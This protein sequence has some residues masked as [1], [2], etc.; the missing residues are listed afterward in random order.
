[1]S[2]TTQEDESM[3]ARFNSVAVAGFVAVVLSLGSGGCRA[4]VPARPPDVYTVRGVV[5]KLPQTNGP[6]KAV[7]IHHAPIPGFRNER[8]KVVGMMSMT[9]PFPVAPG[10][11]LAGIAPGDPVKFTFTVAWKGHAGY[12][13]T[14][15]DKLP[16]GTVVD[17]EP[18][19]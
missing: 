15:I 10:V 11:S 8:G 5:E 19:H 6:D 9:M 16:A 7:Y 13:I 2:A 18:P 12:Q 17:F 3:A 1:V 4:K 14:K